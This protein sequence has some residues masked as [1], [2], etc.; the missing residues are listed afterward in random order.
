MVD[1]TVGVVEEE[2]EVEKEEE[3]AVEEGDIE[4]ASTVDAVLS[5]T[6]C[7]GAQPC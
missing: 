6:A 3:E 2:E 7:S 5:L 4:A 1:D